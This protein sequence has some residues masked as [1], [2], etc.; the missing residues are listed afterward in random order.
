[1]V[2]L[3][4]QTIFFILVQNMNINRI[5]YCFQ[6]PHHQTPSPLERVGERL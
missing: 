5:K 3:I 2:G 4:N 1:M 6:N